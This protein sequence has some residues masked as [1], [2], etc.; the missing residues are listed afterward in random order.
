MWVGQFFLQN[1]FHLKKFFLL[2]FP[3]LFFLFASIETHIDKRFSE[4]FPP[5]K[6]MCKFTFSDQS[7]QIFHF[8]RSFKFIFLCREYVNVNVHRRIKKQRY[9]FQIIISLLFL[10]KNS[11]LVIRT[12]TW[13]EEIMKNF[14]EKF[15]FYRIWNRKKFI[16]Y[17]SKRENCRD[18]TQSNKFMIT[19]I[20]E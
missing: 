15:V 10:H 17:N 3:F 4:T 1:T 8:N 19:K 9:F 20:V 6:K 16:N 18:L 14:S 13:V 2:F 12:A 5:E 7:Q 11:S